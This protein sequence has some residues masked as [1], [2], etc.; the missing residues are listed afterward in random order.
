MI[1]C[2]TNRLSASQKQNNNQAPQ[3]QKH[4]RIPRVTSFDSDFLCNK[5]PKKAVEIV[6]G[7]KRLER[8]P[9]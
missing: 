6:V 8:S 7:R 3:A 9:M 4:T 5:P 2:R 1:F